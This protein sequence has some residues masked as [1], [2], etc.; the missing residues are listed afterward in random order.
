VDDYHCGNITKLNKQNIVS[1][2]QIF[3]IFDIKILVDFSK[4]LEKINLHQ[5]KKIQNLSI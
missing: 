4:K 3:S 5:E 2:N 1:S